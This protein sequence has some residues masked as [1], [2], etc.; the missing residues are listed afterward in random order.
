V[1]HSYWKAYTPGKDRLENSGSMVTLVRGQER[2]DR[3][4]GCLIRISE[5]FLLESLYSWEEAI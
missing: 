5:T 4:G 1:R 3:G 2:K